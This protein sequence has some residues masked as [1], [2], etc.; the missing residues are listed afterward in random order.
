MTQN[1]NKNMKL[2]IVYALCNIF[3]C[4][5]HCSFTHLLL[6]GS[7]LSTA[8]KYYGF[9]MEYDCKLGGGTMFM[10]YV[11][12]PVRFSCQQHLNIP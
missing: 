2:K 10:Q 1:I 3:C 12:Y 9:Y 6:R 7:Q 8:Q 4:C 11:I 5:F